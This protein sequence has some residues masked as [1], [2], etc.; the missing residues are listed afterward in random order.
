[1]KPKRLYATIDELIGALRR[2]SDLT[3]GAVT[4]YEYADF[5]SVIRFDFDDGRKSFRPI[6]RVVNKWAVG[7]PDVPL[8]LYRIKEAIKHDLI[9]VAE[10]EKPCDA[11]WASG[12]PCVTSAHGSQSPQRSDWGPLSDKNV[13]ILPDNDEPGQKYAEKVSELVSLLHAAHLSDCAVKTVLL[14]D[15]PPRGDIVDFIEARDSR[16]PEQL[17]EV[18]QSLASNATA[19]KPKTVIRIGDHLTELSMAERLVRDHQDDLRYCKAYGYLTWD[20]KRWRVDDTGEVKRRIKK[21]IRGLY[22]EASRI[23]DPVVLKALIDFAKRCETLAR[24]CFLGESQL[25]GAQ[26][27]VERQNMR[28]EKRTDLRSSTS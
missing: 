19:W 28:A 1:M 13:V 6:H 17:R 26:K 5:F 7:D 25:L 22:V 23:E 27:T 11:A 2:S 21:V 10:G 3:G 14:P 24:S 12:I 20:R 18:I 15:L 9:Y 16:E 4:R 8:P